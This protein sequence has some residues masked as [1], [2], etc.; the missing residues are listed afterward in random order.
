MPKYV[1]TLRNSGNT[2]FYLAQGAEAGVHAFDLDSYQKPAIVGT[3]LID[4]PMNTSNLQEMAGYGY[5]TNGSVGN[6]YRYGVQKYW[7][8]S[9][10]GGYNASNSFSGSVGSAQGFRADD[11]VYTLSIPFNFPFFGNNKT[12]LQVSTNGA[13]FFDGTG[14]INS[15][16]GSGYTEFINRPCIAPMWCDLRTDQQPWHDIYV[17]SSST[18]MVMRW[19]GYVFGTTNTVSF[20]LTLKNNGDIIFKYEGAVNTI[21]PSPTIGISNG[22]GQ[23]FFTSNNGSSNLSGGV[24]DSGY[25][26]ILAN[27][28]MLDSFVGKREKLLEGVSTQWFD[29]TQVSG[30]TPV[31]EAPVYFFA[32]AE[33]DQNYQYVDYKTVGSDAINTMPLSTY[34]S[35][36]G[37]VT[38]SDSVGSA[39]AGDYYLYQSNYAGLVSKWSSNL[40]EIRFRRDPVSPT[41]TP[42]P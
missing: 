17:S 11:A 23:Y 27:D 7:Y 20:S 19:V 16:S 15:N 36:T 39:W 5:D 31:P 14:V 12:S 21:L 24:N 41:P 34:F 10:Y 40:D 3:S 28:G 32:P 18:E 26:Y 4:S 1:H 35:R 8:F 38:L 29:V 30:V 9:G 37:P 42:T 6:Y 13:V 25:T 22:A 2:D 33:Q